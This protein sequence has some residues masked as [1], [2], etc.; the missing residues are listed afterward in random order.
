MGLG[1]TGI[2]LGVKWAKQPKT[3]VLGSPLST[4]Q[5][6]RTLVH[7]NACKYEARGTRAPQQCVTHTPHTERAGF[8]LSSWIFLHLKLKSF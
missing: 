3:E 8:Y 1:S 4:W 7:I 6:C 5:G 2:N